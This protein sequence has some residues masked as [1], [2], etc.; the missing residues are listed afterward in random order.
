LKEDIVK[1]SNNYMPVQYNF[2]FLFLC[3][4]QILGVVI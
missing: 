1:L 2:F 4:D 3:S